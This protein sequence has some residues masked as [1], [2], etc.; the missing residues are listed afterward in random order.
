MNSKTLPERGFSRPAARESTAERRIAAAAGQ[1]ALRA[2]PLAGLPNA[3]GFRRD[4]PEIAKNRS[5]TRH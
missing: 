5:R 2:T 3:T 4:L 1:K